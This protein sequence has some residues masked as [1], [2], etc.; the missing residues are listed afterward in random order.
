M[1]KDDFNQK[2][3]SVAA[4]VFNRFGYKKTTMDEIAAE[5]GKGKSSIYYYFKS[6]EEIFKAV[7][8]KEANFLRAEVRKSFENVNDP[9]EQIKNYVLT[10]MK[11][12][13][14]VINFNNAMKDDIL[15]HM[16]FV[17]KIRSR[18]DLYEIELLKKILED[19]VKSG[20]FAIEDP[21]MA[22]IGIATALK[23]LE[24]PILESTKD[25]DIEM[26]L[27]NLL[28]ILFNGIIKR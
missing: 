21:N 18:F 14:K 23:G 17:K 9:K 22:S 7:V 20:E 11:A 26:R 19:G 1:S 25:E 27:D 5:L 13:K 2:I 15:L 3:V 16:D 8:E 10:R 28:H 6:K 12:Y 24:V 4:Q